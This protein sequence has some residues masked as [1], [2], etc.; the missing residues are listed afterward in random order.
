MY[1]VT[2]GEMQKMDRMTIES[3]GI[4][5]RVLMEN[6]GRG[7]VQILFDKYAG[8]I[9][10]RIGVIAGRGNNGG[11]GF[12]I[13]RY[14]VQKGTK[15]TVYLLSKSSLIKGDAAANLKLLTS[16]NVPVIEILDRKAFLKH[17]SSI[18]HQ[19]ILVDAILGTG[20]KSDVKGYFREVIEFLNNLNKPVFAVDIPSGLNSDTGQACGVCVRANITATFAF[21][22]IGQILFPGANYTGDLEIVEIGIPPYIAE[23]IGPRQYLLTRDMISDYLKPRPFDTHKGSMGHLLLIAGSP[24]KTGAAT[25][26][27]MSAMRTGAGLVTLGIPRSLNP[28]LESQCLEVMTCSLSETIDGMFNESSFQAIVDLLPGK[29]CFAIGPGIGTSTETKNLVYRII[30]ESKVPI[31][32]DADGLNILAEHTQILRKLKVPVVLTPHPGEMARLIKS[33][34]DVVQKNRINCARDFAE[35]FNVNLVLKGARTIIAHPDGRVF[36]NQTGNSGMASGGM[37]DVLT[38]I[39]AGLITQ[40]YSPESATHIG[41]YLHG[42]AA[43]EMAKTIGPIGF[44]ASDV[45]NAIPGEIRRLGNRIEVRG[46]KLEDK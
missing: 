7:A 9:N 14:L 26:T 45:M 38:G 4:P 28:V 43:D 32:I 44:L 27:A 12:V 33:T 22:K 36:V 18:V 25:M 20:L 40:G 41:V 42:S 11:D 23:E 15:V 31:V 17:R 35:K 13:A 16:L 19:E 1:L 3:F 24:G 30:Q 29:K 37:G 8:V 6:A 39:I 2:A 5:G 46:Q 34:A 10:R 21:A